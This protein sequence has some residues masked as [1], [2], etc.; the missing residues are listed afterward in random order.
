MMEINFNCSDKLYA[1]LLEMKQQDKGLTYSDIIEES[2]LSYYDITLEKLNNID[3]TKI[4]DMS[5]EKILSDTGITQF[6]NNYV[7]VYMDPRKPKNMQIEGINMKYEPVYIGKGKHLRYKEHLTKTN[8]KNFQSFL[9]DLQKNNLQPVIEIVYENLTNLESHRL[10]NNLI[11][12]LNESNIKLCNISSGKYYNN[13]KLSITTL[14]LNLNNTIKIINV[15]NS[16][17][18]IKDA[19]RKLNISERTLFRK[20]KSMNIKKNKEGIY[21]KNLT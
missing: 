8:N 11:F 12:K 6:F 20:L 19:A 14:N 3:T 13:A 4:D 16:T 7:Y 18:T 5:T 17:K 10:E 2:L 9:D 1:I 21:V 15:L